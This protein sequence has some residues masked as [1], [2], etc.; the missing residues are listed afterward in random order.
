MVNEEKTLIMEITLISVLMIPVLFRVASS[1][2]I[3]L[4]TCHWSDRVNIAQTYR[5]NGMKRSNLYLT[6]KASF[7]LSLCISRTAG[8]RAAMKD[9]WAIVLHESVYTEFEKP[10]HC[11]VLFNAS[12]VFVF[13]F[14]SVSASR[15][16]VHGPSS[17]DSLPGN[18]ITVHYDA[19]SV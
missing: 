2:D 7:G 5:S 13:A 1:S 6:G 17:Y 9:L 16:V 11:E 4:P 10:R 3:L 19:K 18:C 12:L 15:D 14:H 8:G